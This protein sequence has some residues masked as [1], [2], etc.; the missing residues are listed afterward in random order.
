LRC[1]WTMRMRGKAQ[2]EEIKVFTDQLIRAFSVSS[3]SVRMQCKIK[4]CYKDDP[5]VR[6]YNCYVS[7]PSIGCFSTWNFVG[8]PKWRYSV[9]SQTNGFP[10]LSVISSALLKKIS[11]PIQ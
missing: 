10:A 1:A 2:G 11:S 4:A 9:C 8:R 3:S 5:V 7:T 6:L